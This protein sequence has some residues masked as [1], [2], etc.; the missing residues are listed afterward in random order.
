MG[1]GALYFDSSRIGIVVSGSTRRSHFQVGREVIATRA[2]VAKNKVVMFRAFMQ[3]TKVIGVNSVIIPPINLE[4]T[5]GG[6][7][8][9]GGVN[10]NLPGFLG[11]GC[12]C[13]KDK[14]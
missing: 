4:M 3:S 8:G 2:T 5:T 14:G 11:L 13:H 10:R 6:T 12:G 1:E 7:Y 9:G